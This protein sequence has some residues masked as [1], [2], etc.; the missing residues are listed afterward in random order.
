MFAMPGTH[1]LGA[2]FR[3]HPVRVIDHDG[4]PCAFD[5]GSISLTHVGHTHHNVGHPVYGPSTFALVRR[6][7]ALQEHLT[8]YGET[9]PLMMF[10]QETY[11]Q[12]EHQGCIGVRGMTNHQ[13]MFIYYN[14]LGAYTSVLRIGAMGVSC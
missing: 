13:V 2:L 14:L 4:P 10:D 11:R 1:R 7:Q 9:S 3:D 8:Q 12:I 5:V 6:E